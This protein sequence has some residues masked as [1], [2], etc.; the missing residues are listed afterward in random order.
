MH[1]GLAMAAAAWKQAEFLRPANL[2]TKKLLIAPHPLHRG[3]L[4]SLGLLEKAGL[5]TLSHPQAPS[6]PLRGS[7]ILPGAIMELTAARQSGTHTPFPL[8]I[9]WSEPFDCKDNAICPFTK[10]I[11]HFFRHFTVKTIS[12]TSHPA[13]APFT[14]PTFKIL[15]RSR[16]GGCWDHPYAETSHMVAKAWCNMEQPTLQVNV[17]FT[18]NIMDSSFFYNFA[19]KRKKHI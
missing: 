5:L 2:K 10:N 13:V 18:P 9:A 16:R 1:H 4:A 11:C 12:S 17:F 19:D 14:A 3:A 15:H 7:G 8:L 6:H